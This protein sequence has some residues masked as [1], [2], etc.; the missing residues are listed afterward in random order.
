MAIQQ[1]NIIEYDKLKYNL[2]QYY[3]YFCLGKSYYN[4]GDVF[5]AVD[6][7]KNALNAVAK[8]SEKY[9]LTLNVLHMYYFEIDDKIDQ[10]HIIFEYIRKNFKEKFPE[11]WAN[12]IRGCHNFLSNQEALDNLK[13]AEKILSNELEKA[14][15]KTTIGFVQIKSNELD[16]A[17]QS[18]QD[19]YEII[20]DIKI[21]ESSYVANNLALCYM[22]K[23]NYAKAKEILTE[24][25]LWNRTNYANLVIQSNLMMCCIYLRQYD[26]AEDY[27]EYLKKYMEK[28]NS[29]PI[30]NRK[31]YMNLAIASKALA[32]QLAYK[33]YAQKAGVF[34][35]NTSSEWRYYCLIEESEKHMNKRPTCKYELIT[36][37]DPWFLIY[38]HD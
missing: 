11:I 12:T 6:M 8:D 5:K 9:V 23:N 2:A 30:L 25:L 13:E 37:F 36:S 15:I 33:E 3:F 22:M 24:A 10:S 20:K 17:Q 31:I 26:E 21:H 34:A 18:F 35:L 38:A 16:L 29:D 7:L 27:Y 14:F 1:L 32:N 4:I 28:Q 19:A